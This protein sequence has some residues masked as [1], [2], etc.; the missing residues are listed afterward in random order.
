M[1]LEMNYKIKYP[2]EY[3]QSKQEDLG[4][5]MLKIENGYMRDASHGN[6]GE[7]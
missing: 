7:K 4:T 2:V 5:K 3:L 1:R 6:K